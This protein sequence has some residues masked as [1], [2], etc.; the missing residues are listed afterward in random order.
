MDENHQTTSVVG[1]YRITFPL[2]VVLA[3]QLIWREQ[4]TAQTGATSSNSNYSR[5][6][7]LSD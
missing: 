3:E 5:A 4:D 7:N 2:L 6:A 1:S